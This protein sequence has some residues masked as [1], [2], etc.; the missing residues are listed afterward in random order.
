MKRTEE[1]STVG[2]QLVELLNQIAALYDD[3]VTITLITRALGSPDG[4]RDTLITNETDYELL[5]AALQHLWHKR[6]SPEVQ[7]AVKRALS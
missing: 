4:S 5:T 7:A 1:T 2:D 6:E 3:D